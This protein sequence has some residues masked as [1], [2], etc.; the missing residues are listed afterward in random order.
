MQRAAPEPVIRIATAADLPFVLQLQKKFSD[1][2]GFLPSAALAQYIDW[3]R[4]HLVLENDVPAGYVL[5]R[6]N[7]RSARWCRPIIQTAVALD[8]Q[9]RHNGIALVNHVSAD[10]FRELQLGLQIWI[11]EDIEAVDFFRIAGF[12]RIVSRDSKNA[13]GRR[14]V[15]MRKPLQPFLPGDFFTPPPVAGCRPTR[16]IGQHHDFP[17]TARR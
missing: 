13:R 4:V 6:K 16:T 9:R 10:S 5:T 7:L 1:Q 2:L 3:Q 15:L 11:A 8:A 12:R 14:L 17:N